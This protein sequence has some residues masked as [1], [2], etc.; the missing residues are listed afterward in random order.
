MRS[1]GGFVFLEEHSGGVPD[2]SQSG[3]ATVEYILLLLFTVGIATGL[4][5]TIIGAL[6]DGILRMGGQ[7][8]K[9]LK[10]GRAPN[11]VW[12]N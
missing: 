12:R 10:S 11:N 8:Q 5:R 3:Q 4:S 6:D 7:L 1:R 2:A 9:D